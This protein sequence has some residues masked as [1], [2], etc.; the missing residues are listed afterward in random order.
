MHRPTTDSSLSRGV[1]RTLPVVI[2]L[3][4]A[5][6]AAACGAESSTEAVG[7]APSTSADPV[8]QTTDNGAANP[9]DGIA[10][11]E[12]DQTDSGEGEATPAPPAE[13]VTLTLIH[14]HDHVRDELFDQFEKDNPGIT[15]NAEQVPQGDPFKQ[16]IRTLASTGDLPD[17]MVV[18]GGPD[19][20]ALAETGAMLDLTEALEEPAY[21][22][23]TPWGETFRDG[24]LDQ[25][26]G[27]IRD[28]LH[29]DGEQL[30][31]PAYVVAVAALYNQDMFEELGLEAPETWD[32]FM[33]NNEA[34]KEA[35]KIPLSVIGETFIT[36]WTLLTWDQTARGVTREQLEAGDVKWTDPSMVDG[37]EI[38][39]DMAAKGYFD[40]AGATNGIT[41][42]QSLF[43]SEQLA[44]MVILPGAVPKYVAEQ[45]PFSV[46]A[47]D[48]P[49]AKGVE[50]V[51]SLGGAVENLAV[52]KESPNVEAAVQ[53]VKYMTSEVYFQQILDDYVIPSIDMAAVDDPIIQ[54]YLDAS[55][56]GFVEA[57]WYVGL[58]PEVYDR[59][60]SVLLAGV[61]TGEKNAEQALTEM[62]Q[63]Y[64]A[65]LD[66]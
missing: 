38:I 53:L 44:Q 45:A 14:P 6:L 50:P 43:L 48:L 61:F 54:A 52:N 34:L 39:A 11:P 22:S 55:E 47:F 58:D 4:L 12:A 20:E 51:R 37:V 62:E 57:G 3:V 16:R 25:A 15:V 7:T 41:E 40:P 10:S 9:T 56:D 5:M 60:K 18:P 35:G 27:Y 42:T 24:L 26:M 1:R 66:G 64:R 46:S 65:S 17:V 19:M 23:E 13:E 31:V 2:G 36:W 49:G 28:D 8:G 29:P 21:D 30:Q 63:A 59:W 33:A 32:E